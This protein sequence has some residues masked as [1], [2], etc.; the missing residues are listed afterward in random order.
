MLFRSVE[1]ANRISE[2]EQ[3]IA[4]MKNKP[5]WMTWVKDRL[6]TLANELNAAKMQA[7]KGHEDASVLADSKL[8][9]RS[10]N[11]AVSRSTDT[12]FCLR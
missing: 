8:V 6:T 12:D 7:K 1:A 11:A 9:R 3:K 10:G 5:Q 4:G 2:L